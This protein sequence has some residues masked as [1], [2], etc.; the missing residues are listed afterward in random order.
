MATPLNPDFKDIVRALSSAR[1]RYLVVGGFAVIEHTEPRYTKDLDLWVE[2]TPGNARKVFLALQRFG[3]PL[4]GVTEK[5]FTNEQ[6]VFQMG[7]EPVRI[8]ILMGLEA[9]S[10]TAAWRDRKTVRWGAV[11]VPVMSAAHL[12]ANKKRV[13]RPQDLADVA[14]L[15]A[16]TR[17][18]RTARR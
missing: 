12:I 1:V 11:R 9:V 6:L 3:A 15:Q 18:A 4:K 14:R 13:A 7:V 16:A 10:F 8:D 2:P 17:R 5:D